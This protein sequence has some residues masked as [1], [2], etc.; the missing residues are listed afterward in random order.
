MRFRAALA[1]AAVLA[2]WV[3]CS[4]DARLA[5]HQLRD[6]TAHSVTAYGQVLDESASPSQVVYV[7]L[8]AVADDYAAGADRDAREKALDIQFGVSAAEKIRDFDPR[9]DQVGESERN[10]HLYRVVYH[11]A[12]VI[13]HYRS[14]FDDDYEAMAPRIREEINPSDPT[15]AQVFVNMANPADGDPKLTGAVGWFKLTRE[16]GF[17][18]IYWIGFDTSTRDWTSRLPKSSYSASRRG[19]SGGQ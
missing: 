7:L 3:G 11:W 15:E 19:V 12:P 10:E 17:W 16:R 14:G 2:L 13:G 6:T 9:G 1:A 5:D 18:R 4:R 8:K